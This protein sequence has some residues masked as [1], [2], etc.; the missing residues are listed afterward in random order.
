[1]MRSTI[2]RPLL[3]TLA[4][5]TMMWCGN[6]SS[7]ERALNVESFISAHQGSEW[8]GPAEL[9]I[10]PL[11]NEASFSDASL[12]VRSDALSYTWVY[13]GRSQQ[14][15]IRFTEDGMHWRDSWHQPDS[16]QIEP[17]DDALGMMTARYAYPA[18]SGPDW[19]WRI[20]LSQRPDSTL[21]L[22]MTNIAPWGEEARAVRMILSRVD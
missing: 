21:V 8:Q 17:I 19:H 3:M 6:L 9:W 4:L 10:D 14:G 18:G 16:V 13:K 11:G 1:M 12:S 7:E 15:Q 20:K 22:A 5:S 2:I